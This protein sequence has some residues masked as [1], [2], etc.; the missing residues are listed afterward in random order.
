ME[1]IR[2]QSGP[3]YPIYPTELTGMNTIT[4]AELKDNAK[5]GA[6]VCIKA[7]RTSEKGFHL[8]V[9]LTWKEGDLILI[10][11]KKEPRVWVSADRLLAHIDRNYRAVA[12]LTIYLRGNHDDESS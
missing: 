10:N 6:V 9:T 3:I 2:L 12:S 11:Q 4:E 7:T 1:T 5:N 8:Y